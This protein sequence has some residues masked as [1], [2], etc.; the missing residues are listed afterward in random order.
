MRRV[1][2]AAKP[3]RAVGKASVSVT[4]A[5][6]LETLS[7]ALVWK[8]HT[9]TEPT[10]IFTSARPKA[11]VH[12]ASLSPTLTISRPIMRVRTAPVGRFNLTFTGGEPHALLH[13]DAQ[14]A[15]SCSKLALRVN[16]LTAGRGYQSQEDFFGTACT[17][18]VDCRPG[19]YLK[20]RSN[21]SPGACTGCPV[22][23]YQDQAS[24]ASRCKTKQTCGPGQYAEASTSSSADRKCSACSL[25]T[26]QPKV[27]HTDASCLV[28]T[29]CSLGQYT[30]SA[31]LTSD[32]TCGTCASGTFATSPAA[33]SCTAF[34]R[35]R[36]GTYMSTEG[37]ATSDRVCSTCPQGTYVSVTAPHCI[38]QVACGPGSYVQIIGG[39]SRPNVCADCASGKFQSETTLNIPFCRSWKSC[40]SS[41][42]QRAEGTATSDRVCQTATDECAS[43]PCLNGGKCTDGIQA[44][45]CNCQGTGYSGLTCNTDVN[46]CTSSPCSGGQ[47]CTNTAVSNSFLISSYAVLKALA[48]IGIVYV[49]LPSR[50]GADK[51][52][53]RCP[54]PLW[55]Q[56][57][58][59]P[60]HVHCRW[61]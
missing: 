6:P 37:T 26:Y 56:A 5:L 20:D 42:E 4:L 44:F 34:T 30:T 46:E 25:G 57:L 33:T 24:P 7:A 9:K 15:S 35:C 55:P 8:G 1:K 43:S 38:A 36:Q 21:T 45:T 54:Q 40:S 27:S 51:R 11:T 47:L 16:S 31:S 49:R 50:T 22:G 13:R 23:T 29:A 53:L 18:F 3:S 12:V 2:L 17:P 10:M 14:L 41:Q 32:T 39:T 28:A 59:Q 48:I 60:S 19:Q 58:Q 52:C 61:Q